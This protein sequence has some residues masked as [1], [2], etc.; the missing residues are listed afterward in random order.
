MLVSVSRKRVISSLKSVHFP[1][2]GDLVS[3]ASQLL[4]Q[5]NSPKYTADSNGLR[6]TNVAPKDPMAS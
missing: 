2:R 1:A 4:V 6:D 5:G 3:E